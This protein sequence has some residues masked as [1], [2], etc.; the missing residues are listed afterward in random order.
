MNFP[1]HLQAAG[2]RLLRRLVHKCNEEILANSIKQTNSNRIKM[3]FV[4]MLAGSKD[5]RKRSVK[6]DDGSNFA[7][8]DLKVSA[9]KAKASLCF[10]NLTGYEGHRQML[11]SFLLTSLCG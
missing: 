5:V 2:E 8:S 9:D 7:V 11:M 1:E 4:T 10:S 3:R 6:D